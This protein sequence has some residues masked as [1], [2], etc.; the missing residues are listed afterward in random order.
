MNDN[1]MQRVR[2][3]LKDMVIDGISSYLDQ[4][5]VE[6]WISMDDIQSVVEDRIGDYITNLMGDLLEEVA[7]EVFDEL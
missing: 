1:K 3:K 7:D 6:D 4:V 5:D 2:N